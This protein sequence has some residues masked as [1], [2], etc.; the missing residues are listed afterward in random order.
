MDRL[1]GMRI[2]AKVV[3]SG[4]F[5]AAA[6]ALGM[7]AQNIAQTVASLEKEMGARFLNRSTRKQ[8]L[9]EIGRLFYERCLQILD[10]VEETDTLI[11]S[12]HGDVK[13]RLK[14]SVSNTF[15]IYGLAA[16]L[17]EWLKANPQVSLN[18]SISNRH[19]DLIEEGFD[20]VVIDDDPKDSSLVCRKITDLK[21]MLAAS[22]AYVAAAPELKT[23]ADL[24]NHTLLRRQDQTEW[25]FISPDGEG[26]SVQMPK[27]YMTDNCQI[28]AQMA[29]AGLG[30]TK[31]PEFR[32]R[33]FLADG[34]LVPVLTDYRIADK[35]LNILYPARKLMT[36]KVKSFIE[37]LMDNFSEGRL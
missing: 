34:R 19:V 27:R 9:T 31:Q 15:G 37:F 28:S 33:P 18:L 3:E 11:S 21:I 29:V 16:K 6:D 23:P 25:K 30:I 32:L 10:E 4:S 17:P 8:S 24:L 12:Y 22:P 35:P 7:S 5:S 36:A 26:I 1:N 14:I 13:G 20:L 2:F